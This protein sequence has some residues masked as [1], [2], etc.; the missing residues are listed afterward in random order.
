[1][2]D[3]CEGKNPTSI[4]GVKPTYP[5]GVEPFS[6]EEYLPSFVTDSLRASISDFDAWMPG[7]FDPEALLTGPETRSTSPVRVLRNESYECPTIKGLYPAG[8]GAGYFGGIVSS[9]VDGIKCAE[10]ILLK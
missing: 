2:S 10:A 3:F 9:A 6:T 5:I 4:K 8:E 1:M 7:F